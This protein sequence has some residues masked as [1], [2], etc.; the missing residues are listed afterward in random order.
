MW[1]KGANPNPPLKQQPTD[2]RGVRLV[3]RKTL[4]KKW[5]TPCLLIMEREAKKGY[6]ES[7]LN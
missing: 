1:G 4:E 3:K 5:S 7:P 2:F 6:V